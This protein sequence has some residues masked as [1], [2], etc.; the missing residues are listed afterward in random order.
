MR[1]FPSSHSNASKVQQIQ[2]STHEIHLDLMLSAETIELLRCGSEI[3]LGQTWSNLVKILP[4][5]IF[6]NRNIAHTFRLH[7]TTFLDVFQLWYVH[8]NELSTHSCTGRLEVNDRDLTF[9]NRRLQF[10]TTACQWGC[11][12]SKC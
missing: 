11:F 6:L 1:H 5:S 12:S 10:I 8:C 3:Q 9:H 7:R 4:S 2:H